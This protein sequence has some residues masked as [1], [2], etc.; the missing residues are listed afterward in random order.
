M[1]DKVRFFDRAL[2]SRNLTPKGKCAK[3]IMV[4]LWCTDYRHYRRLL[5]FL[6]FPLCLKKECSTHEGMEAIFS[7]TGYGH[8]LLRS[9]SLA[10][11]CLS[12]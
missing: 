5:L 2:P 10:G 6:S 3:K 9:H 11:F 7:P 8:L 4:R 1:C 12:T